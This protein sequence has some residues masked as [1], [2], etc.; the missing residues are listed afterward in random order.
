MVAVAYPRTQ[1]D[2]ELAA[3]APSLMA[4]Y[5]ER[6]AARAAQAARPELAPPAPLPSRGIR[7]KVIGERHAENL[8]EYWEDCEA[9][10]AGG[11]RLLRDPQVL[12]RLFPTHNAELATIYE[13]RCKRAFYL[14]Y[15][16]KIINVLTSGL[17]S[18]P[19]RLA[20]PDVDG[21][22]QPVPDQWTDW[23]ACVTAPGAPLQ[24]RFSLHGFVCEA[25]RKAQIKQHVWCMA[26]LP[27]VDPAAAAAAATLAD[28]ER[29]G[30]LT[31][32]YLCLV[33][34]S[35]VIN[36]EYDED[37]CLVWL[38]HHTC[39]Q[40]RPNPASPRGFPEHTWTIWTATG[41]ARYRLV[42]D[43]EQP[44]KP[45][46]VV[47]LIDSG[48]HPFG[49]VPWL[50]FTL[51]EGLWTM[52]QLEGPAREHFNKRNALSWAEYKSLFAVLYEFLANP[53]A[54]VRTI[55]SD[56]GASD[57]NR[58]TNQVRGQGW[59]QRR[60]E[61][62][63]AEFIGPD[64]GPFSEARESCADIMQEMHRV[65]AT[66]AASADMNS[67]ALKRSADSKESDKGDTK[68]VL[69]A[70]GMLGR[71][72]AI[73]LVVLVASGAPPTVDLPADLRA[74][75][76]RNF[77]IA[78]IGKLIDD[79]VKLYA[80]VPILSP[81]FKR[82]HLGQLYATALGDLASDRVK[83]E[84]EEE[85]AENITAEDMLA[86][87]AASAEPQDVEEDDDDEE[88]PEEPAAKPKPDRREPSAPKR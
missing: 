58:A 8:G 44:A 21:E 55:G 17:Q 2:V 74:M 76:M 46:D 86:Q 23:A 60:G 53:N 13:E 49:C 15:A 18:D 79:A 64:P 45:D 66:M 73:A 39:Q 71:E 48:E 9:L 50:R 29:L 40:R 80:G 35:E 1:L 61:K 24:H 62:D 77:D 25:I 33:D 56:G 75:G 38:I 41:W 16:G 7:L 47:P 37:G 27:R 30:L 82:L 51:P 52:G 72:L 10:Y 42:V 85:L 63:R 14:N 59:T 19:V 68:V 26:D 65:T 81:T 83:N 5:R 4:T 22:A 84:M 69:E 20:L 31:M 3:I 36:W 67:G 57:P 32:P 70:F 6:Q 43:P 78:S 87:V 28:Q 34:A 12:R 88:V 54:G 11:H